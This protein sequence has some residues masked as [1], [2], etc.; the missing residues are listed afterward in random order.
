MLA[1]SIIIHQ[2]ATWP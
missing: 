1:S 2:T